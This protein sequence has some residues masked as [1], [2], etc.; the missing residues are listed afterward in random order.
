MEGEPHSGNPDTECFNPV[1]NTLGL[2]EILGAN[3]HE[4][5]YPFPWLNRERAYVQLISKLLN[6]EFD[7]IWKRHKRQLIRKIIAWTAGILLVV[8][9]LIAVKV[10]NQPIDACVSLHETSTHNNNLPPLKDAVVTL[11]L[12]N[13][14]ETDTL[15]T[16]D[17][18]LIFKNIPHKFLNKKVHL[19]VTGPNFQTTTPISKSVT[20]SKFT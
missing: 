6:V 16:M 5:I 4:K 18:Q 11:E 3:I 17:E 10:N 12:D 20:K 7:T 9:A 14:T 19:T 13:K 1:V 15:R 8:A 2:P